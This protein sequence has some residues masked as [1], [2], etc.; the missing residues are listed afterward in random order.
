MRRN[1]AARTRIGKENLSVYISQKVQKMDFSLACKNRPR[2]FAGSPVDK[3]LH[4]NC[5]EHGFDPWS[6][7]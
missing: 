6:G 7:N 1:A 2:N 4:F 3:T 5:R